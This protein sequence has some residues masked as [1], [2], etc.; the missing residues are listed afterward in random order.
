MQYLAVVLVLLKLHGERTVIIKTICSNGNQLAAKI[1]WN[2]DKS[3]LKH[4]CARTQKKHAWQFAEFGSYAACVCV[5]SNY[6][7]LKF[8]QI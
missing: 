7:S 4:E 2:A 1:T 6:L 3:L 8:G 5:K